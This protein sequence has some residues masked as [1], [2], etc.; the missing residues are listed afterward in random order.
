MAEKK[1]QYYL[2][3]AIENEGRLRRHYGVKEDE[4]IPVEKID[5]DIARLHAKTEK[6]GG[7]GLSE[8]E[9]SFLGALN[10]AKRL[11]SYSKGHKK[12]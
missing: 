10:L 2:A 6:A 8:E 4:N 3:G 7:P 12:K 9:Q 1:K 11:R 5:A